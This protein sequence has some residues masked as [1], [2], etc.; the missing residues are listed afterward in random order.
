VKS[1]AVAGLFYFVLIPAH[2]STHVLFVR[3]MQP[4]TIPVPAVVP[5][6]SA[7]ADDLEA[8]LERLERLLRR[9]E[10]ALSALSSDLGELL[11]VERII[12]RRFGPTLRQ[13]LADEYRGNQARIL[14]TL[15]AD[16]D[17]PHLAPRPA[18]GKT[19]ITEEQLVR[20]VAGIARNLKLQGE[21][22]LAQLPPPFGQIDFSWLP[23]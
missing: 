13:E 7:N 4:Q 19:V 21:I 15:A 23:G 11:T 10:F 1:L 18:P 2:K 14:R 12:H 9:M 6:P 17:A 8:E 20:S 22:A 16:I 5:A 3:A